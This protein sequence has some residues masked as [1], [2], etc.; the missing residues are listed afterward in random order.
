MFAL[1]ELSYSAD[2]RFAVAERG[3]EFLSVASR[4]LYN[5]FVLVRDSGLCLFAEKSLLT[6][7]SEF[8]RYQLYKSFMLIANYF[9]SRNKIKLDTALFAGIRVTLLN[10]SLRIPKQS[11]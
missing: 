6:N 5:I 3:R 1:N 8:S 2:F 4:K 11:L 7:Q 10:W 9:L